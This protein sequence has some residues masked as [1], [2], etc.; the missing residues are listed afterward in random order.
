[1]KSIG[2]ASIMTAVT[3]LKEVCRYVRKLTEQAQDVL[4]TGL[5][6]TVVTRLASVAFTEVRFFS[7]Q[8]DSR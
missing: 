1:M 2:I 8:I 6:S 5:E 3:A 7:W 4:D